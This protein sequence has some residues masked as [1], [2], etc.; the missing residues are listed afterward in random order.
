[1]QVTVNYKLVD[2]NSK[3]VAYVCELTEGNLSAGYFISLVRYE[4][5]TVLFPIDAEL[6]RQISE[7]KQVTLKSILDTNFYLLMN[8]YNI[9]KIEL[10]YY[11]VSDFI[12]KNLS[13]LINS[14]LAVAEVNSLSVFL[15]LLIKA[16]N[17]SYS[18]FNYSFDFI[19]LICLRLLRKYRISSYNFT[20]HKSSSVFTM[21]INNEFLIDDFLNKVKKMFASIN[22]NIHILPDRSLETNLHININSLNIK[23]FDFYYYSRKRHKIVN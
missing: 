13:S 15:K 18:T 1:M 17:K 22:H 10:D 11:N 21:R 12:K 4:E 20:Y 14:Q 8:K 2:A 7:L 6:I 19:Q 3:C 16:G 23:D 5:L 9:I